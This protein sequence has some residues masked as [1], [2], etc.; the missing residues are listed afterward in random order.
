MEIKINQRNSSS[1]SK[2]I[3]STNESEGSYY[4]YEYIDIN[5]GDPIT[6]LLL[7][8]KYIII[9]TMMGKIVLFTFNPVD[10]Q[11]FV[12]SR[13]NSENISGLS[14]NEEKNILNASI[15]AEKILKYKLNEPMTITNLGAM[16]NES[17][18]IYDRSLDYLMEYDNIYVL[19]ATDRLLK[20]NIFT[21]LQREEIKEEFIKYEVIF[22][23]ETNYKETKKKGKINSTN[24][25]VPLDFDGTYFCWIEYIDSKN[26]RNLCVQFILK[27]ETIFKADYKFNVNKEY[28][29]INHAKLMNDYKIFIVHKLNKCEIRNYAK[30]FELVESFTHNGDEVYAIDILYDIKNTFFSDNDNDDS[31]KNTNLKKNVYESYDANNDNRNKANEEKLTINKINGK[32]QL[33]KIEPNRNK[34]LMIANS[35][36]FLTLIK[37]NTKSKKNESNFV[38]I[39][40]DIDGNINKYENK[41]EENLFNLYNIKGIH[42]DHKDKKFFNFEWVYHIKTDLNVFCI[43]SDHGCYI[44]K[45]D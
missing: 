44:I 11:F 30:N 3:I 32:K 40:L 42:Q 34:K 2:K 29:H 23:N 36:D 22:F 14:F 28:G 16:N 45:K 25:Y 20:V 6:S 13:E 43:T 17:L 5:I 7:N 19:M 31:N 35:T 15:G 10:E 27:N 4:Y 9:G 39:T 24:F 21:P 41:K 1:S 12:L 38:I 33:P 8:H 26:N 37:N 18:E